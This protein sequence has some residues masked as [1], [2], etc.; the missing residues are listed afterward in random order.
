[1]SCVITTISFKARHDVHIVAGGKTGHQG[2]PAFRPVR[3]SVIHNGTNNANAPTEIRIHYSYQR[4]QAS[5]AVFS[6]YATETTRWSEWPLLIYIMVHVSVITAIGFVWIDVM[7]LTTL[8]FIPRHVH[9]TISWEINIDQSI[10]RR[11]KTWSPRK[12][13]LTSLL[14]TTVVVTEQR[15]PNR[16]IELASEK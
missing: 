16:G 2:K 4:N 5:L 12:K 14:W 7:F 6:G 15:M 10:C 13:F 1:M 11:S 8:Q 9:V 3:T